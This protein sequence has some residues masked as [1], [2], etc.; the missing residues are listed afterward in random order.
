MKAGAGLL[1]INA[2]K[3]ASLSRSALSSDSA[4]HAESSIVR[5]STDMPQILPASVSHSLLTFSR[6]QSLNN[7]AYNWFDLTS[8]SLLAPQRLTQ[9]RRECRKHQVKAH[10]YAGLAAGVGIDRV[11]QIRRENEQRAVA[12]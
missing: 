6:L 7:A 10:A 12:N 3:R 4:A 2:S 11:I 5:W 1:P 9:S 8:T